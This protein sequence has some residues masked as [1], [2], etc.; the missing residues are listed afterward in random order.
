L[1][2]DVDT[3]IGTALCLAI[4]Q[5]RN[6]RLIFGAL[7]TGLLTKPA[8]WGGI[9]FGVAEAIAGGVIGDALTDG[10]ASFF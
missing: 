2:F 9:L 3:F 4:L 8:L 6:P 10:I 1:G 5:R 7:D